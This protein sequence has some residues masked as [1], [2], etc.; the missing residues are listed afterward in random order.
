MNVSRPVVVFPDAPDPYA[1][2]PIALARTL[3]RVGVRVLSVH[4]D[5]AAPA[6]RSRYARPVVWQDWPRT[7]DDRLAR[8]AAIAGEAAERPI[9]IPYDDESALFVDDHADEL[10]ALF[11][12]PRRP[13]GLARRLVDKRRLNAL[14]EEHGIS[15]PRTITPAH[16]A[17]AERFL[18][19]S[20]YP[21]VLKG[22]H[23]WI[24]E[25]DRRTRIV[26]ARDR[27][28]ALS[29]YRG[30]GEAERRNVMLQE[31][32]PGGPD[33]VWMFNGY[34]D[35][36]SDCLVGFTGKKLRQSP[37][38]TGATS[39]GVCLP[40]DAV[41]TTTKRFMKQL[42]YRGILDLG[43]RYDA[44]DGQYKLLDVNPRVGATFRL[45]VD[46]VAEMDVVRA[47]YLHLTGQPVPAAR[48]R[49]GRKW[50]V[51][52]WDTKSSLRYRRDGR[53]SGREWL[54]SFRG[55]E[56]AAWLAAD[57]PRPFLALSGRIARTRLRRLRTR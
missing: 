30:M 19:E 42:G 21:V 57:D 16:D 52:P 2:T 50:V 39:L 51:E 11:V 33:S 32:I 8:L 12:F 18:A 29:A 31:Y 20:T 24:P 23:S 27:D 41:A 3:G 44:R 35:D 37:P 13:P 56:E 43:Y 15:T 14:C 5:A 25:L 1:H 17:D 40:N 28:T 47:L 45:F 48:Q 53:L 4:A 38:Y 9:L 6:A 34:F 55:L 26:I 46:P 36:D 49:N 10:S 22:A 7:A 54:R